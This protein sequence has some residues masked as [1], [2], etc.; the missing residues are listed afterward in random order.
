MLTGE[1]WPVLVLWNYHNGSIPGLRKK[2][3]QNLASLCVCNKHCI[4]VL[5][6][7]FQSLSPNWW[8]LG[9]S[10]TTTSSKMSPHCFQWQPRNLPGRNSQEVSVITQTF[11]QK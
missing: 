10:C 8:V 11:L 9:Q 2:F 7:R 5:K 3:N 4:G 6:G 1:F